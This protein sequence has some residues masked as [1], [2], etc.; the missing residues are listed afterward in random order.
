MKV[1]KKIS[2]IMLI[3]MLITTLKVYAGTTEVKLTSPSTEVKAGETVTVTLSAVSGN[4]IEA[5]DAVLTY[6]KTKL[7]LTNENALAATNFA[8]ISGTDDLT[9]EFR[10][11]LLYTG[12][13]NAPA[14]ADLAQLEFEVLDAANVN[15]ILNIK[16]S[17]ITLI[18]SEE[19][20]T[21]VEDVEI[22]LTVVD[23]QETPE[24]P[25]DP[26]NP[27]GNTQTPGDNNNSASDD[28]PYAGI[29]NYIFIIAFAVVLVAIA[30]YIKVSKYRDIK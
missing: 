8:S 24:D 1:F 23:E 13:G 20:G 25:E 18:D 26:D 3:L 29:E 15:D 6:D 9:G 10:L 28:Y 7:Q 11:S 27:G 4:G 21:E 14:E 12:S 19:T 2:I 22:N 5:F 17:D 16:L 30:I